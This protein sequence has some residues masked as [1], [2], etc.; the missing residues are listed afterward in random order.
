MSPSAVSLS[1][2]KYSSRLLKRT[3]R[4]GRDDADVDN[5]DHVA[6]DAEAEALLR[7]DRRTAPRIIGNRLTTADAEG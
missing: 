3:A 1:S 2:T 7:Q 4:R 6:S 5:V